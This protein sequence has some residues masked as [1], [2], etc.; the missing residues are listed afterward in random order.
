MSWTIWENT[1]SSRLAR[2]RLGVVF[3]L[4][5]VENVLQSLCC[6]PAFAHIDSALAFNGR[7]LDGAGGCAALM[8]R[9]LPQIVL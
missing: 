3:I 4:V 6:L 7:S 5:F 1:G 2:S 8:H 9:A